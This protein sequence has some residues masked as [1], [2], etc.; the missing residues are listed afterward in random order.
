MPLDYGKVIIP[1]DGTMR[2]L[3][4]FTVCIHGVVFLRVDITWFLSFV[5][6]LPW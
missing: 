1:D 5:A 6:L 2:R 4:A 3:S